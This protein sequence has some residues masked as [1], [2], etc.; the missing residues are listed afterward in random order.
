MEKIDVTISA[1]KEI[2]ALADGVEKFIATCAAALKDGFQLGAD[3][4]PILTSAM[5]DL[6]P[7]VQAAQSAGEALKECP[8]ETA[9]V[10]A[11]AGEGIIASIKG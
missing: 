11:K 4:P 1:P 5:S 9:Y 6:L 8:V 10:F 7:H 3:F 2:K